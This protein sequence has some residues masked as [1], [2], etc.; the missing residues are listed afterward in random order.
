[1]KIIVRRIYA[2]TTYKKL[3]VINCT[4]QNFDK[5]KTKNE[6][7]ATRVA[8]VDDLYLKN[9]FGNLNEKLKLFTFRN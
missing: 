3:K 2:N 8:K 1:M 6:I 9:V 4:G 5:K 7:S